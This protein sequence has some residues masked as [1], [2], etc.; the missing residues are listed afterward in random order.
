MNR[1]RKNRRKIILGSI[2][3][4]VISFLLVWTFMYNHSHDESVKGELLNGIKSTDESFAVIELFTSEGCSSCPPADRLFRQLIDEATDKDLRIYALGFHVDYW[5]DLGWK[6]IFSK[7]EFAIRQR[8]YAGA[9]ESSVYTPQMVVNGKIQF[10]GSNRQKLLNALTNVFSEK[11]QT[12][13][14]IIL[15]SNE[16][17]HLKIKYELSGSCDP[18]VINAAL[19]ESGL[20]NKIRSGENRGETLTHSNVVRAFN[21]VPLEMNG[22]VNLMLKELVLHNNMEVII[23]AQSLNHFQIICADKMQLSL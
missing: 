2:G 6:D 19:V 3:T 20:T 1:I 21:V 15:V 14:N 7:K 11:E 22:E 17:G 4:V 13:V 12:K 16:K 23:Y 5:N 8:G 18:C 9:L 10:T